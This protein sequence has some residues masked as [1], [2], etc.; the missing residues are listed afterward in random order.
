MQREVAVNE[1]VAADA[2]QVEGGGAGQAAHRAARDAA[3]MVNP[4][5]LLG[6]PYYHNIV[7]DLL[8]L[9]GPGSAQLSLKFSF[10]NELR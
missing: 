6:R 3:G 5:P 4:A 7:K 2:L 10:N 1:A 8:E 9:A